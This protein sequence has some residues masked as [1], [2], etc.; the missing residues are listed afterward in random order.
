ML[1][2][3][4]SPHLFHPVDTL[5]PS[6]DV[7]Q[8]SSIQKLSLYNFSN[9][10]RGA[11]GEAV[12]K[13]RFS[14]PQAWKALEEIAVWPSFDGTDQETSMSISPFLLFPDLAGLPAFT[15]FTV[16]VSDHDAAAQASCEAA[17]RAMAALE[18][19]AEERDKVRY[20][21][22]RSVE[23]TRRDPVLDE[24]SSYREWL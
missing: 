14:L 18:L 19:N 4:A 20:I 15:T 7:S 11:D 1:D 10:Y 6:A 13:K 22:G 9:R 12:R 23:K 17:Y 5:K 21:P 24:V 2:F 8:W 16:I 3:L